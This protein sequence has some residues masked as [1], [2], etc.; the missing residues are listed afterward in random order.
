[1]NLRI[2]VCSKIALVGTILQVRHLSLRID[3]V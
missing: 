2:K 1:V 3:N